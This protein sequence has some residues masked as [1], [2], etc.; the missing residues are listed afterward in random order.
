MKTSITVTFKDSAIRSQLAAAVGVGENFSYQVDKD[1]G[2]VKIQVPLDHGEGV[3]VERTVIL[4]KKEVDEIFT[5]AA[6]TLAKID[7]V[8]SST[9][10]QN[11][12][13][14]SAEGEG[15]ILQAIVVTLH[16]LKR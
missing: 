15:F 10:S 1:G 9:T 4:D 14:G 6:K 7:G 5:V 3:A 11:S 16:S 13:P 2:G 12:I 8:S